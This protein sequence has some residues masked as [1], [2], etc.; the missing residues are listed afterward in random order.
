METLHRMAKHMP[1]RLLL[2]QLPPEDRLDI[3]ATG[4]VWVSED[5][6]MIVLKGHLIIEAALADICARFLKNPLALERERIGI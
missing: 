4:T 3:D 2:G 1:R 5:P 6:V